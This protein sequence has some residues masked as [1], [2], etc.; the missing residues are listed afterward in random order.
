[1]TL[2]FIINSLQFYTDAEGVAKI[3]PESVEGFAKK[4]TNAEVN[5]IIGWVTDLFNTGDENIQSLLSTLS[6]QGALRFA[7]ADEIVI[8]GQAIGFPPARVG[9]ELYLN[10]DNMD[11]FFGITTTGTLNRIQKHLVGDLQF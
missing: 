8:G 1:M 2:A 6:S 3:D 7:A 11:N 5:R 10:F 4:L 9:D